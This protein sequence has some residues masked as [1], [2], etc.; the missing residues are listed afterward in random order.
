MNGETVKVAPVPSIKDRGS[1]IKT[2]AGQAHW[3]VSADEK[4]LLQTC[5]IRE[6]AEIYGNRKQAKKAVNDMEGTHAITAY[7][8][9]D[10]LHVLDFIKV[11]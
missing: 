9:M 7:C 4:V 8:F 2:G 10:C 3:K 1:V 5:Y 11:L 6:S